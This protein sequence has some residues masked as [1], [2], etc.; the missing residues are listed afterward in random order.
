MCAMSVFT[1]S[2]LDYLRGERRLG[3]VATIGADGTPHVVPVGWSLDAGLAAVEICGRAEA[4]EAPRAMIRI[5]P[6]RSV[7]WGLGDDPRR[8]SRRVDWRGS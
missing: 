5:H 4:V 3:R 1:E 8:R 2:E 6:E 7:S